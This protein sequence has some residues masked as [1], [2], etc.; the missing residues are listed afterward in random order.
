M[1]MGLQAFGPAIQKK[2]KKEGGGGGLLSA[3]VSLSLL[4]CMGAY[5]AAAV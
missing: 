3:G 4:L 2:K 1:A 5:G